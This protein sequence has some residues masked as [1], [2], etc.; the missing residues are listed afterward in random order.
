MLTRFPKPLSL[1]NFEELPMAPEIT[2]RQVLVTGAAVA[3]TAAALA[4][5]SS[6]AG[7]PTIV[8]VHGGPCDRARLGRYRFRRPTVTDVSTYHHMIPRV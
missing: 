7:K 3:G 6:A 2:R 4:P 5:L 8:L 1:P